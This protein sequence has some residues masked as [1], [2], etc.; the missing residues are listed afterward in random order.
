MFVYRNIVVGTDFSPLAQRGLGLAAAVADDFDARR[1]H[2]VHVVQTSGA[3]LPQLIAEA[4]SEESSRRVVSAAEERLA[5]TEVEL[6]SARLTR[7]VRIG[8]PA[9]ELARAADELA[10][11][12][13]VVASHGHGGLARLMLG[14]AASTLIRVARCPVLVVGD[15][16]AEG[17]RF[18]RILAA[19]DLSPIS[20]NVLGHALAVARAGGAEVR[21]LSLY[22]PP[23]LGAHGEGLLPQAASQEELEAGTEAQH[24]EVSRLLRRLPRAGVPLEV[25]VTPRKGPTSSAILDVARASAAD[26]IVLGTSGRNA[27]HRMI[28]GSTAHNVL[29]KAPCPILVVPL[30]ERASAADEVLAPAALL[31]PGR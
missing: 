22:E 17:G 20:R 5:A 29:V 10:A 8:S 24:G 26:L 14:S 9:R 28:V 2:L 1:L 25:D 13:L 11:D 15:K 31:E 3:V 27:W 19:V 18:D 6:H 16:G 23:L 30:E 21:I 4:R 7:E 12:L